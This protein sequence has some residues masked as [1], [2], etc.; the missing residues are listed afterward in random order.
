M[1]ETS[2]V[3]TRFAVAWLLLPLILILLAGCASRPGMGWCSPVLEEDVVYAGSK[4]GKLYAADINTQQQ[5]W[6]FPSERALAG[7]YSTPVTSAEVLFLGSYEI[8][9]SAFLVFQSQEITGKAYAVY[10]ANGEEKWRFPVDGGALAE[11]FLGTP[12]LGEDMVYFTSTDHKVYA[13]DV[14]TGAKRWEFQTGNQIWG[15]PGY[16][17]GTLYVGSSDKN[18]Y[19]LNAETGERKWVFVASGAIYSTPHVSEDTVYFGALDN[20]AYAL[21]AE[22][23]EERWSFQTGNWVWDS[24]VSHEETVYVPS[25]DH[26]LYALD[27]GNAAVRWEFEANDMITDSPVIAEG[28]VYFS[29]NNA[30]VY[31]LE[32]E[33]G[34]E[35]WHYP[36][37]GT[38]KV[39][40]SPAVAD[41]LVYVNADDGSLYALDAATGELKWTIEPGLGE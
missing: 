11:P 39:L 28:I 7:I 14:D 2:K 32:A 13:L 5:L 23:G 6:E 27:A 19:A 37:E 8:E 17:D 29:A 34:A 4:A 9:T 12:A 35:V 3:K 31:A 15:G 36:E 40:A 24:P 33:T 30:G 41:Q 38:F 16:R 18:L 1:K 22:N 25:L 20:K 10:A 26:S 21:N